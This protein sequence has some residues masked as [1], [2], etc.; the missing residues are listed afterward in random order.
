M[1]PQ[2]NHFDLNLLRALDA[3]LSERSVTRA[4]EKLYVSQ[5]AMSGSLKRL[6]EYFD[7]DLLVRV[8]VRLE[9]TPR[10]HALL[11]PVREVLLKIGLALETMPEFDAARARR[12]FRIAMSDDAALVALPLLLRRL[13]TEAP[14]IVCDV[15][16]LGDAAFV[17]LDSGDLDLIVLPRKTQPE[18]IDTIRCVPLYEDDFV[19]A[20]DASVHTID[21]M[22]ADR[23]V[24]LPHAAVRM[25]QG[26]PTII[27][28]A[29]ARHGIAPRVAVTSRSFS[30]LMFMIAGTPLVATVQRRLAERLGGPLSIRL[31]PCPVPIGPLVQELSWHVRSDA[32]PAHR[33]LRELFVT[34]ALGMRRNP[35]IDRAA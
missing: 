1:T 35:G 10:G 15:L 4:A 13:V 29:W 9:P 12:R 19:C 3:L 16:P 20:V 21:A 18:R 22:T 32:D 28:E 33:Y 30:G 27:D 7:D 31:L 24:S 23:Y 25:V 17:G 8:G 26:H 34:T 14:G 5:Q 2:L 6:R 11:E